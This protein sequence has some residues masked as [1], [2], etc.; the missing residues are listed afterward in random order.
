MFCAWEQ[1]FSG[2]EFE[3]AKSSLCSEQLGTW[4]TKSQALSDTFRA[5]FYLG[6]SGAG[7]ATAEAYRRSFMARVQAVSEAEALAALRR[8]VAPLFDLSRC[9]FTVAA[10]LAEHEAVA[11]ALGMKGPAAGLLAASDEDA[12]KVRTPAPTARAQFLVA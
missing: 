2:V 9:C 5:W 4:E 7:S 6:P 10:P 3:N 8:Y 12:N 11:R 1:A